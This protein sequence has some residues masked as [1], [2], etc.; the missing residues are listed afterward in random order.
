MT[1]APLRQSGLLLRS[2]ALLGGVALGLPA[3]TRVA[4]ADAGP[5]A[6]GRMLG[7]VLQRSHRL[8]EPDTEWFVLRRGDQVRSSLIVLGRTAAIS[9][10]V[11]GDVVVVDGDLHLRPGA[12]VTGRAVAIGG[13]VY[14]SVRAITLG[15]THSFRD[16]TYAITRTADG[17]RLDYRSLRE[18]ASP[19]LL[20]PGIYGLRLPVYDRVNGASIPFGPTY[21]L[22]GG[23]GDTELLATYRSDLGKIDPAIVARLQLSRYL[24][25]RV[26]AERGTFTNDPWIWPDFINSLASLGTGTDTRNYYRA[27]RAELS[28]HRLWE[29]ARTQLEPFVGARIERAWSVGP[30]V[31]ERRGPW[32]VFGRSDTLR[33]WRPNPTIAGGTISSALAGSS[34]Q[35]EP[36][37]MRLRARTSAEMSLSAPGDERFTQ[38]ST[39][40]YATFP[41]FGD[42]EYSMEIRWVTTFGDTPPPQRFSYLGGS[43]TLS[44]LELLEQGGDELL[45]IDQTYSVPVLRLRFGIL[46]SPTFLLR[47]RIG[48]AGIG[49]LPT[50]EQVIGAGV[51]LMLIRGEIQ[52][53]PATGKVRA[54]V[55]LALSR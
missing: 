7:E 2:C 10:S 18:H 48:S 24:R 50:F 14:P 43:G 37:D 15:G 49:A 40:F 28:I 25:A 53:D 54:S 46:G 55:G 3:Q 5:G 23:R 26:E 20:L 8:I 13:G 6:G 32:S 45:F 16:N 11:V 31:G 22:A 42:Q 29:R 51:A 19:S 17:Y 33:M 21:S 34:L 39:D 47:H 12:H 35:W 30:S 38:L 4:I 27:D 9:G 1:L 36:Q 41:T 52:L 44:F